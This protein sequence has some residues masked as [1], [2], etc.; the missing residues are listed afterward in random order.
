MQPDHLM[1]EKPRDVRFRP[2][3]RIPDNIKISETSETKGIAD[4]P[5]AGAFD[6][7]QDFAGLFELESGVKRQ[8]PRRSLLAF[9]TETV[10]AGILRKKTRMLLV[11]DVNLA[12][13][14]NTRI[15]GVIEEL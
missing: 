2:E 8:H 1:K 9:R 12:G 10:F 5:A 15:V 4:T 6:V 13:K 7:E 14:P 11:D 3:L